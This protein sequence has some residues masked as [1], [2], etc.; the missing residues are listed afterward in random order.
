MQT[1]ALGILSALVATLALAFL[2]ACGFPFHELMQPRAGRGPIERP[3]V[4]ER[5]APRDE[6]IPADI[7]RG[8]FL[9]FTGAVNSVVILLLVGVL[10]I[11][12]LVC[13][14]ILINQSFD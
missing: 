5:I 3:H 4:V 10:V 7:E 2:P 9:D 13:L 11:G 14:A 8:A 1:K 12:G 6:D